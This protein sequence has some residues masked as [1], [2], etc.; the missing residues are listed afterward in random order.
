[1]AQQHLHDDTKELNA[2]KRI[3]NF[4]EIRRYVIGF[5]HIS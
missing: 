2:K 4:L 5:E 3:S 1:M